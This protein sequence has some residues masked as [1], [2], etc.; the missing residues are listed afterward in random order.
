[1]VS[2]ASAATAVVLAKISTDVDLGMGPMALCVFVVGIVQLL[3][4]ILRLSRF[5]TLVPYSVMLGFV[6]GLAI[7]MIKAQMRQFHEQGDGPWVEKEVCISMIITAL[8]AMAL[9]IAWNRIP[10]VSKYLPAPLASLIGT[11]FFSIIFKNVLP[12][13]TL[14]DVAGAETF[15][16]GL[17]TMP[18]WNF[19]PEG[20]NYGSSHVWNTVISVGIRFAI[21]GLLESLMTQALIDQITGTT[22]SMRRECFGQGVGNIL[23]SLFGTQ[24]GCALIAQS[25]LNVSSG[26]HGR[27]SGVTVGITLFLSVVA[28]APL[29]GEIPVAALVGLIVLVALNTFAWSSLSLILRINWVDSVVVVLVTAIT[30][31]KDLCIAVFVGVIICGLGFAWTSASHVAL[32]FTHENRGTS[33]VCVVSMQ[34][35][36]FFGSAMNYQMDVTKAK[37]QEKIVILDFRDARIL[38][39]SATDAIEKTWKYLVEHEKQVRLRGVPAHVLQNLPPNMALDDSSEDEAGTPDI[40]GVTAS[41]A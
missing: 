16:G 12:T 40:P 34:G 36:L 4:G 6:N 30:V 14:K 29:M 1:M 2:S 39:V 10:Y 41:G 21:V 9:A 25:L 31:W 3:C 38:D 35:A 17:S 27:V 22:G 28:A 24:G 32:K 26:G 37:F 13:R 15:R 20:V 33:R 7:V 23:A 8:V 5:I 11:V 19:P 18:S